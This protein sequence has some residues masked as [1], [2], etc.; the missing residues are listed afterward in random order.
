VTDDAFNLTRLSQILHKTYFFQSLKMHELDDLVG[1]MRGQKVAKGQVIIKQGDPG[2][3]FYL[4][5][6]G[7]VSVWIKKAFSKTKVAELF[8]DQFF[9][10]MAL[11]SHE[12]RSAT[13]IAEEDTT[14]F[15]LN[16]LDFEKILMKNPA[17]AQE[18]RKAFNERKQRNK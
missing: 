3:S 17:V 4:I 1:H 11:I 18:L 5:A 8:P 6:A 7:R 13:I 12:P 16:R 14:L 10:E 2:L 9:G 15:V